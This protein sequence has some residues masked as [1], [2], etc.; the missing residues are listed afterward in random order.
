MEI[1]K[2]RKRKRPRGGKRHRSKARVRE[3]VSVS[4][5]VL[6]AVLIPRSSIN[7]TRVQSRRMSNKYVSYPFRFTSSGS[8][9]PAGTHNPSSGPTPAKSP[10]YV[11]SSFPH[12]FRRQDHGWLVRPCRVWP[13]FKNFRST[14]FFLDQIK[15]FFYI[16][17]TRSLI[18]HDQTLPIRPFF[19]SPSSENPRVR[20]FREMR[21]I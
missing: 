7:E 4:A 6:S 17:I 19:S 21:K 8:L 12:I 11:T 18:V 13:Q 16:I 15:I 14:I 20:T 10:R 1:C 5:R 3:G 2:E 9:L